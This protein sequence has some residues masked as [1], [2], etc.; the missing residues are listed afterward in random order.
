MN[1]TTWSN[2]FFDA[3]EGTCEASEGAQ[4]RWQ[5]SHWGD[6]RY[7]QHGSS[8]QRMNAD[9]CIRSCRCYV[10]CALDRELA[11]LPRE[12]SSELHF[13][14]A[15]QEIPTWAIGRPLPIRSHKGYA[16]PYGQR[17]ISEHTSLLLAVVIR[18]T[19]T[20]PQEGS[21]TN[22]TRQQPTEST[23]WVGSYR[24]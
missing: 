20:Q 23:H 7:G 10:E 12:G 4:D 19:T 16:D 6:T 8:H 11:S 2:H 24:G 14:A 3:S 22:T 9:R 15:W 21:S 17:S 1:E 5:L 18:A 13:E